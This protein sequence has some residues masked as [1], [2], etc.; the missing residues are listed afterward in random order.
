[1]K[2]RFGVAAWS[3]MTALCGFAQT[4]GLLF[5]ARIG[6]GVGEATLSPAAYSYLSDSFDR[7]RLPRA[8]SVY[9]LG[10]FIGAGWALILGGGVIGAVEKIPPMISAMPAPMNR[11]SP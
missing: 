10:L 11:P 7:F 1:M 9:G 6:V 3:I 4:Y 8:M 2:C 5:L